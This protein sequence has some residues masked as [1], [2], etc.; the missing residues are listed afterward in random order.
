MRT[1]VT[2]QNDSDERLHISRLSIPAPE[3]TTYL[4]KRSLWTQTVII[5]CE[6]NLAQATVDISPLPP[7]FIEAPSIASPPRKTESGSSVRKAI[8]FLLG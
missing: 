8:G 5:H 1:P 7:P 2:I 6:A 4:A 3:L